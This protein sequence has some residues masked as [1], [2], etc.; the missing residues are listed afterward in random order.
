MTTDHW[1]SPHLADRPF[2][3]LRAVGVAGDHHLLAAAGLRAAEID[4]VLDAEPATIGAQP[5]AGA[6]AQPQQHRLAV[7]L[8][9][10]LT[11]GC[12]W[13]RKVKGCGP[14]ASIVSSP[15]TSSPLLAIYRLRR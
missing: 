4:A 7:A 15:R 13:K 10:A 9:L 11:S 1:A 2:H 6:G 12:R 14:N 3:L 5:P 8:W